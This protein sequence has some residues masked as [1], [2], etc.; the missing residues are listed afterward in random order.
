MKLGIGTDEPSF[1]FLH[2]SIK[3]HKAAW[4]QDFLSFEEHESRHKFI[5]VYANLV[6]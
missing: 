3:A 6:Q 1:I 2:I 4:I 5:K